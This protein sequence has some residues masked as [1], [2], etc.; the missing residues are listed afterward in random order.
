M[1]V[2]TWTVLAVSLPEANVRQVQG[3][4]DQKNQNGYKCHNCGYE[5]HPQHDCPKV[6][7]TDGSDG[8]TNSDNG[9]GEDANTANPKESVN[10]KLIAPSNENTTVTVNN[11]E[12]HFWLT[13]FVRT[14]SARVSSTAP[15]QL[16]IIV[17]PFC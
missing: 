14:Q 4:G 5:Y 6:K 12:Y 17:S 13:V 3:G 8:G 9:S 1:K 16:N 10:W 11:L 15:T 7:V 2:K